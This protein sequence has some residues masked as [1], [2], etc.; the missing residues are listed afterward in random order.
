[1]KRLCFLICFHLITIYRVLYGEIIETAHFNALTQYS[2]PETLLVLDIDDTLLVPVQ[3]L[4][5]DVWFLH[6]LN[7]YRQ[8]LQNECLALDRALADWEAIRHLTQVRIVEKGTDEIIKKLQNEKIVMMG[9]TTQGLALTTRTINQLNSLNID[10]VH[11]APSS[12]DHYFINGS[13]GVL[14]RQGILFTS[15]TDK[16]EALLNFLQMVNY[17]PKN[18]V[19]INDKRSHIQEV[20]KSMVLKGINF[21]GL[22]YSYSDDRVANFNAKIA[23]IQW[24]QSTFNHLI[25]DEEAEKRLNMTCPLKPAPAS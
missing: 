2:N 25:S 16:G 24:M 21:T 12:N 10:L 19:F 13:H 8:S 22:R 18:I 23:E 15:G 6:R 9:L 5:S 4:G 7:H 14:Y 11:T 17:Y 20:E 3:T 1:M